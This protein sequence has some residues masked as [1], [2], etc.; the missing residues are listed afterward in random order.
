M[1]AD[2]PTFDDE[3]GR[4]R[5]PEPDVDVR[6]AAVDANAPR[7]PSSTAPP[8]PAD[9]V[10]STTITTDDARFLIGARGATKRKLM[11]VS[12]ARLEITAIEGDDAKGQRLD[13]SGSAAARAKAKRYV[14]W[15][16]RQRVGKII[17]DTS[18]VMEDVSVMEVPGDC[19]AYVTGKAGQGLRR[20]EADNGTLLF[21]GKPTTDPE[22]APEKLIICGDRKGRRGSELQVMSSIERKVPGTF[23][24]E[25]KKLKIR[26]EQPGD[27]LGDGWGFDVWPFANEEE[28]SFAVGRE[29]GRLDRARARCVF[30]YFFVDFTH[31]E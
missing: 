25:E 30:S 11:R 7:D 16:L 31:D 1:D 12:G 3:G 4:Q 23:V 15:V 2:V 8:R 29:V 9:E 6:D 20:I 21:F 19:T 26:F 5:S 13:I 10:D 24:D 17:V 14:E 28:L 18:T 22:D 27:G